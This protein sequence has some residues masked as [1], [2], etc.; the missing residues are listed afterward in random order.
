MVFSEFAGILYRHISLGANSADFT[1][2]LFDNILT[3]K[4]DI[5]P[6]NYHPATL[7]KFFNGSRSISGISKNIMEHLEPACF[8]TYIDSICSDEQ[9]MNIAEDLGAVGCPVDPMN[10]GEELAA[11]FK[12]IILDSAKHKKSDDIVVK[13][14]FDSLEQK[15]CKVKTLLY[16]N[17][18]KPIYEFYVPNDL[19]SPQDRSMKNRISTEELI[20]SFKKKYIIITGTGGLGKTMLMRHLA[21]TLI[22]K[23]GEYRKLPIAIQL[24]DCK[25]DLIGSIK[26][27]VSVDNIEDYLKN[28][29][30]VFLLDG[31][32][33]IGINRL[34]E[35][36]KEL[37]ELTAEYP[38]NY[39]ILSSRPISDFIALSKFEVYSLA[40][41]TKEQA[42]MLIDKLIYRPETPELKMNFRK[43]VDETLYDSHKEFAENPLFLTIM[44]MTYERYAHIPEKLH[45]F[46][47][48]IFSTLAEKH[49][50]SKIGFDR[51]FCTGMQPEDFSLIL[52]EFCTCSYFDE[53]YE[54]TDDEFDTYFNDLLALDNISHKIKSS[55]LKKDLTLNLCVMYYDEGKYSFIHRSFQEYFCASYL[56]KAYDEGYQAV[57]DFFEEHRSYVMDDYMFD[58]L[59]DMVP[60][61]VEKLIFIPYLDNLFKECHSDDL[62]EQYWNFLE[63]IYPVIRYTDGDVISGYINLPSSY[64]Y[65]AILCKKG[66]LR[67]CIKNELP[68]DM[69]YRDETYLYLEKDGNTEIVYESAFDPLTRNEYDSIMI[70]GHNCSFQTAAVRREK[71]KLH[72]AVNDQYFPYMLEYNEI[73]N[74]L[75]EMKKRSKR[76]GALFK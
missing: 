33:E 55:D 48:E 30:C 47:R 74:L 29:K 53:K 68:F 62:T 61:K 15:L 4:D 67:R 66:T 73:R 44:F 21:L 32:D 19:L 14:Y 9:A 35:F 59:Y 41:L 39:Y 63:R 13:E 7:R 54:F 26:R 71:S 22:K 23:Y 51:A 27:S 42:L 64:I 58:M 75:L 45:V 36:E 37:D 18:P 2:R 17:E 72:N 76:Y 57:R 38:D 70:C 10:L 1:R 56:S 3:D 5:P 8:S 6:D 43:E 31:M 20:F 65:D 25:D 28:G 34:K 60:F 12:Q 69:R 50:A 40:P 46:Y 52:E 16:S 24:R 49:D 11:L